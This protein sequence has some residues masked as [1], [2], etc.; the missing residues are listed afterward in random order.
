MQTNIIDY[1]DVHGNFWELH[2]QVALDSVFKS[3]YMS[4]KS[5]GKKRSS[6]IMWA[7]AL[8][9]DFGSLY[10]KLDE[11]SRKD[12]ICKEYLEDEDYDW[13]SLEL[14]IEQWKQFLTPAQKQMLLWE[15]FM[16]EKNAYL[17][18]LNYAENADE[19]EKRL[20]SNKNLFEEYN[21]LI[22]T[23]AAEDAGGKVKGDA[24]ES[25]MDQGTL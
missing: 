21:R 13:S 24:Q 11:K 19:I 1:W 3:L 17:E 7:V 23:L 2:P 14:Y 6:Q 18:S 12:L 4:D 20:L 16:L 10:R 25:L 8:Y 22:K 9:A 15:R 5:K